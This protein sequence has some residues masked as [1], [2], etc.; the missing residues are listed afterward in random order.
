M[1]LSNARGRAGGWVLEVK[2]SRGNRACVLFEVP[3]DDDIR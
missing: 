2:R 3:R 1:M